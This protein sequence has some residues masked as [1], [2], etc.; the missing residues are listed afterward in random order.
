M[1]MQDKKNKVTVE[2]MGQE[3]I[4]LGKESE[5]YLHSIAL[6]VDKKMRE[7]SKKGNTLNN[8]MLAVLTALNITDEL[9]GIKQELEIAKKQAAKPGR[10]LDDARYQLRKAREEAAGLKEEIKDLRQQ[11]GNSQEEASNIYSEWLKA[12]KESKEAKERIERL[13]EQK[14]ELE[15]QMHSIK[16]Y[17]RKPGQEGQL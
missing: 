1:V 11:L 15:I 4:M 10:E 14:K 7:L 3:Y 16:N 12:Q 6:H 8:N 5:E 9:M 17:S 2:I 13:E